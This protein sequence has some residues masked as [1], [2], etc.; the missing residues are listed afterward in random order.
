MK[1][2]IFEKA[3]SIQRLLFVFIYSKN[4]DRLRERL[5][6]RLLEEDLPLF[7]PVRDRDLDLF[8]ERFSDFFLLLLLRL[9]DL[10]GQEL[11][12]K[13]NCKCYT[14]FTYLW[15]SVQN[16]TE[17]SPEGKPSWGLTWYQITL[18]YLT[19]PPEKM[20]FR[21]GPQCRRPKRSLEN[22]GATS[23]VYYL[24]RLEDELD[25]LLDF[26]FPDFLLFLRDLDLDR[27]ELELLEELKKLAR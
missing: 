26:L 7:L 15:T 16:W 17:N 13:D 5:L 25:E 10:R 8:F 9:L 24:D 12:A 3:S 27:D 18:P 6:D 11:S 1:N 2:S 22:M 19:L 21:K 20:Y 4:L 23:I 14:A